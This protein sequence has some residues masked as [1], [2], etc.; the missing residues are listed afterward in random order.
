LLS[1]QFKAKLKYSYDVPS[2]TGIFAAEDKACWNKVGMELLLD[3]SH[4]SAVCSL[5]VIGRVTAYNSTVTNMD[6]RWL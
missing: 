4:L 3:F 6:G 5:H 2:K 1:S